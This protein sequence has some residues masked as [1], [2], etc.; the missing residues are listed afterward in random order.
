MIGIKQT[1][2]FI[3]LVF[4]QVMLFDKIHLFGYA[5]PLLYI[6]FILQLPINLNRN[7]VVLLAALLGF[8]ID[9]FG[10][11]LGLNMLACIVVGFFRHYLLKLFAP[12]DVYEGYLPAST[13]LGRILFFRYTIGMVFI[14]QL[15]LFTAESF[16][17]FD[18]LS[19]FLRV[20]GSFILTLILI[21]GLETLNLGGV[22]S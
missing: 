17:L 14:H 19:L 11:T 10:Y 16:S 4:L 8:C 1:L 22:K 21:F 9:L 5:T 13:A 18:P 7:T 15:V 12:K 6:Y 20:I 2:W 3:V